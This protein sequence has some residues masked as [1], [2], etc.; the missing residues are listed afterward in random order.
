MQVIYE[1][2]LKVPTVDGNLIDNFFLYL[3]IYYPYGYYYNVKSSDYNTFDDLFI[4]YYLHR[5]DTD[6]PY[7]LYKNDSYDIF[8][9]EEEYKNHLTNLFKKYT[10]LNITI[11]DVREAYSSRT[12]TS[13]YITDGFLQ[14]RGH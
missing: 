4:C 11:E 3:H 7:L 13:R 9:N 8:E 1:D 6:K 14:M 10:G 5:I 2:L 12:V